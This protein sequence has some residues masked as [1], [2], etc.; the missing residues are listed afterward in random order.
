MFG[1]YLRRELMNRRKQT[2][3][4]AIGMALA[5]ALVIVVN[6]VSAGV[7]DAQSRVLQSVYGV[8]TDVTITQPAEAAGTANAGG[9][10]GPGRF[11]FGS[12]AGTE[13]G[14]GS[15]TVHTSRLEV[16]RGTQTLADSALSKVASVDGVQSAAAV[17][18]LTNS[19][20]DGTLPN[21]QQFKDRA[22]GNANNGAAS[23][24]TPAPTGGADGAGGSSFT[25]DS[26]TVMGIKPGAD[27]VGPLSAVTLSK[28]RTLTTGD[29]GKDVAVLDSTYAKK[30]SLAVDDTVTIGAKSFTVVGIVKPTGS[31]SQTAS[32]AYI[33]LDVAQSLSGETGKVTSIF[34]TAKSASD[35]GTLKTALQKA[36]PKATVS[37]QADLA[38]SV[39]GSLGTA[40]ELVANLG[41]WLSLIVLAAAFLIAILF[42][43][44]GVTRRTR[45]FGTL[46]AIGWTNRRIVGQVAGESVVQG[47]IGG[48]VGVAVGLIGVL[49]INLAAP[50]LAGS[51]S[52][53]G[54]ADAAGRAA[55]F[56]TNAPRAGSGTGAGGFGGG[57]GGARQ[58][59]ASSVDVTLNAPVTV[60]I[61]VIAVGL[62]VLGG[63]LAGAIGGWRASR[64]R[65]AE[66]LRSV[67]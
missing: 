18:A 33:P 37:T 63:L 26:F 41:T 32:N 65:P 34:V 64:L 13:S 36:L 43:V 66:A 50:T 56:A 48:V 45:E 47:L 61:I 9:T 7:K 59:A 55:R 29:T 25:V 52:K 28:G 27:A 53:G 24:S 46:K 30:Q 39:S 10:G 17:L 42:T 19:T 14:S 57:F 22:N 67:A 60:W 35:V 44:S 4:I 5:I 23:G 16:E 1:I 38:S 40:S 11:D 21:F 8:G 62:A 6:A 12:G 54:F 2:I 58:A 15:R 31:D 49:V 20:F 3:I 51:T